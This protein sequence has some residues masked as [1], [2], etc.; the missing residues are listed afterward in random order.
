MVSGDAKCLAELFGKGL[1][2]WQITQCH[3]LELDHGLWGT[4]PAF[5]DTDEPIVAI[6]KAV[7]AAVWAR[8]EKRS[9][10]VTSFL[11]LA[12]P[13]GGIAFNLEIGN[14][15][16][17][18]PLKLFSMEDIEKMEPG[19]MQWDPGMVQLSDEPI[20]KPDFD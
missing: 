8:I 3:F 4:F 2:G 11:A 6:D 14:S 16:E 5:D 1:A 17:V 18:R 15:A 12:N 7:L 20:S 9:A 10:K 13:E 19:S